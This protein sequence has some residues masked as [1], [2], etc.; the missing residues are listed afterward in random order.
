MLRPEQLETLKTIEL[1]TR[2]PSL[3]RSPRV[4][5]DL[6]LSEEQKKKLRKNWEELS[7]KMQE[8]QHESTQ[9]DLRI[10]TPKQHEKLKQ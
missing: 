9:R 4:I 8:L 1:R 2:I 6:G 5:E 10:L 7:V 3:L